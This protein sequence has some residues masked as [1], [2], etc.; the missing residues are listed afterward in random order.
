[1]LSLDELKY[2]DAG[3]V[4]AVIQDTRTGAVLMV[5]YMNRESIRRTMEGGKACFWSRSRQKFWV[6]G[7]TSGNFLAV[8]AMYADCDADTL[9][10]KATPRGDG[11]AC[12]TGRYS[13]FFNI[14]D[15]F[16]SPAPGGDDVPADLLGKLAAIIRDRGLEKPR[17]SYT[18]ELLEKG[19]QS[20]AGKVGEECMET[21]QAYLKNNKEELAQE[22]ADLLFHLLVLLEEADLPLEAVLK[23]LLERRRAGD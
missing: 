10:V 2:D 20:I 15:G 18:A 3:L 13:C 19:P 14:L 8:D 16:T 11:V 17:G 1:M 21:I 6:K 4:P 7:E 5:G 22:G 23:V 9:L 12:H